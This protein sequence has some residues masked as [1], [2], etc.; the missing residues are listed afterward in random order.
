MCDKTA[1]E[2]DSLFAPPWS[3]CSPHCFMIALHGASVNAIRLDAEEKA[4]DALGPTISTD[5][6][7]VIQQKRRAI[8][9]G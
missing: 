9:G 2:A 4:T 7:H 1:K 5:N 3:Q 6:Q 8:T